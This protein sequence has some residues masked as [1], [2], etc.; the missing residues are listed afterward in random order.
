MQTQ[1]IKL[2]Y[3]FCFIDIT[4]CIKVNVSKQ[5]TKLNFLVDIECEPKSTALKV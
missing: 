4:Q 1:I 5:K 2:V 3:L